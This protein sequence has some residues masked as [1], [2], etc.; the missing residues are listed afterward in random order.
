MTSRQRVIVMFLLA[1]IVI[2]NGLNVYIGQQKAIRYVKANY[3]VASAEYSDEPASDT[4]ETDIGS[5]SEKHD[6]KVCKLIHVNWAT[7]NQLQE[8]P[9]IGPVLAQRLIETREQ[10]YFVN[11]QD[12]LR[13]PGIGKARLA[14]ISSLVCVALPDEED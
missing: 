9:G 8:L 11:L 7:L 14:Q 10:A 3:S 5:K 12:L 1:L 13:V 2:G 4:G 6:P